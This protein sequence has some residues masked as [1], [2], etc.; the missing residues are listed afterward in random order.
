MSTETKHP[1]KP[2]SG[3]ESYERKDANIRALVQ[4]GLWLGV[5]IVAAVL[6]M[7]WMFGYFARVQ[8]LG[9]PA[10]PFEN[11]RVLP[12]GPRLQVAPRAELQNYRNIE[13]EQLSTYG[14]VDKHNGVVRIPIERAMD[15]VLQHGLA[16]RSPGGVVAPGGSAGANST[17]Q[18]TNSTPPAGRD[19]A[20]GSAGGSQP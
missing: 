2:N 7:K 4:F 13:Q 17:T 16:A 12:P 11:V 10:S 6:G 1:P 20:V 19:S 18:I 14:W 8:P 5:V 3:G 15:L 9:P